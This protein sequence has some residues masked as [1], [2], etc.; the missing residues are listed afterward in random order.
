[1]FPFTLLE[2]YYIKNKKSG[3]R[4]EKYYDTKIAYNSALGTRSRD[5]GV[6]ALMRHH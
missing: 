1:M 6:R 2:V 3:K 5:S 4:N